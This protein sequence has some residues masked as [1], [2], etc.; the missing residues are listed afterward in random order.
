MRTNLWKSGQ[1]AGQEKQ[2]GPA[3]KIKTSF[4]L[5]TSSSDIKFMKVSVLRAMIGSFIEAG[6]VGSF[7]VLRNLVRRP[8]MKSFKK[9]LI[10][11][12]SIGAPSTAAGLYLRIALLA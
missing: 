8:P 9:S 6:L 12:G 10:K 5:L 2:A 1:T 3:K 4:S 7:Y 11:R